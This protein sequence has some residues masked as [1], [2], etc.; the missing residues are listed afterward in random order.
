MVLYLKYILK[1]FIVVFL[2]LWGCSDRSQLMEPEKNQSAI[3][4]SANISSPDFGF[5]VSQE[6]PIYFS[7]FGTFSG[8]NQITSNNLEWFSDKDGIIGV[9]NSFIRSGLSVNQHLIYL[10]AIAPTGEKDT[11][12]IQMNVL[13]PTNGVTVLINSPY[14]GRHFRNFEVF[15]LESNAY[16][17]SGNKISEILAYEWSSNIDG[18]LGSGW[19]VAP[20][21]LTAGIHQITLSV[22]IPANS[23]IV[24]G[25]AMIELNIQDATPIGV[26]GEIS[27]PDDKTRVQYNSPV[28]F[29][30]FARESNGDY[31]SGP[32]IVWT[33]S[34][35]GIIGIGET[36][37]VN[38]LSRGKHRVTMA[39]RSASGLSIAKS[40]LLEVFD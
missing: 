23:G 11:A 31:I 28:T 21:G 1:I 9:G 19:R 2:F 38:N 18:V 8:S 29:A 27:R 13:P 25:S 22:T 39:A 36:C 5:N 4:V 10:K 34:M 33:S 32:S 14:A 37:I 6:Q 26:T 3:S 20:G 7:G 40:I 30:G 16:D 12:S 35:D 15:G 24:T 17:V